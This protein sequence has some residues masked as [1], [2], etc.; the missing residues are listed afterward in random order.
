MYGQTKQSI[1]D[2]IIDLTKEM[3]H[4]S[5]TLFTAASLS[6]VFHISRSLASQYLNELFK[7]NELIKVNER[8]VLYYSR[9]ELRK[10]ITSLRDEYDTVEAILKGIAQNRSDFSKVIGSEYSLRNVISSIKRSLHYPPN[11]MP[12]VLYG[13]NGSGKKFLAKNIYEYCLAEAL[14]PSDAGYASIFC[15]G[16]EEKKLEQALFGVK[17]QC[18]ALEKVHNGIVTIHGLEHMSVSLQKRLADYIELG[19]IGKDNEQKVSCKTRL[20]LLC[21]QD[22][23]QTLSSYLLNRL[24]NSTYIPSLKER[25]I[26]E[27]EVLIL[28]FIEEEASKLKQ[29]VMITDYYMETLLVQEFHDSIQSLKN[30]IILSVSNM[31]E[32][33]SVIL[34]F[35]CMPND[36]KIAMDFYKEERA[37]PVKEYALR[38]HHET[39]RN[40]EKV[41]QHIQTYIQQSQNHHRES[42]KQLY[43]AVEMFHE[44][45]VFQMPQFEHSLKF[46]QKITENICDIAHS[47]MQ[48]T[49][50]TNTQNVIA[51]I[52]YCQ[53]VEYRFFHDLNEQHQ[54]EIEQAYDILSM[55]LSKE[56]NALN[57]LKHLFLK[58]HN[59]EIEG[60]L[61]LLILLNLKYDTSFTSNSYASGIIIAHGYS[62][63]SSIANAVNTLLSSQ[64]F[65]AF[66]MP[67]DVQVAEI[68]K[69]IHAFLKERQDLEN[70][71]I[72]VD[73]GSLQKLGKQINETFDMNIGI[74]NNITTSLALQVGMGLLHKESISELL[75][76][77]S[78][79]NVCQYQFIQKRKKDKAILII[80][81]NGMPTAEKIKHLFMESMPNNVSITFLSQDYYL[82][83][84]SGLKELRERYD[85]LFMSGIINPKIEGIPFIDLGEIINL[86]AIQQIN[87]ILSKHMEDKEIALFNENLLKNFSLV[88]VI[89]SLTIL[90]P[91]ALLDIVEKSIRKLEK[92]LSKQM[93]AKI[94]IGLYVHVCCF[95][96]RMVKG[97]PVKTYQDLDQFESIQKEFIIKVRES[98]KELS[99]HYGI[100][101][102]A[103][104]VAYI[105]DYIN[106]NDVEREMKYLDE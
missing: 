72:L 39:N 36:H 85:R 105:Y 25:T 97:I 48:I 10:Y 37:M 26:Y 87:Q 13:K 34:D 60:I 64:V 69:S 66:D 86:K 38:Y 54:K 23:E 76:K 90:N 15:A 49:I 70:I 52:L 31:L 33:K 19:L 55:S 2:Y 40:L 17:G 9:Q 35:S 7:D 102:P 94:L 75:E 22:M 20:I 82:L 89:E 41:L 67:M 62:T 1:L 8:P 45:I 74:M 99:D 77:A 96:E 30:E 56:K 4:Q 12:V 21:E 104:E 93:E 28:H 42:E 103:S 3:D 16:M 44:Y 98:F 91:K 57:E 24:L 6:D 53:S 50:S 79:M 73:M 100:T 68:M 92:A 27:K 81:E 32:K 43:E 80:S 46:Y 51:S 83:D 59:I 58:V 18:G 29:D 47:R 78:K 71:V 84:N 14:I 5:K 63:A 95:V 11:G 88:N 65:T 106:S 61:K 101:I